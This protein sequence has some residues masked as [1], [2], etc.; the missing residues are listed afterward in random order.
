MM[1]NN[2][3]KPRNGK[4]SHNSGLAAL[5]NRK[6]P[7]SLNAKLFGGT[8]RTSPDP[9]STVDRPWNQV[10]LSFNTSTNG[11]I[12]I[13]TISG[14]F[15][16]QVGAG[17]DTPIMEFRLKSLRAWEKSGA[18][19]AVTI[20]DLLGTDDHHTQHDQPGRNHWACASLVWAASQTNN[21]FPSTS[22]EI[23]ATL[24]TNVETP[25]ITIHC[26]I[27]WRF[28]N[29]PVPTAQNIVIDSK[30]ITQ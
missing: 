7:N 13:S 16:A 26:N 10:V 17:A 18:N 3:P 5:L 27:L 21:T 20:K 8:Y 9:R 22:T 1:N 12:A 30:T 25:N 28:A 29:N 11:N 4:R 15:N 23:I 2:K 24:E 6:N 14:A 19:L